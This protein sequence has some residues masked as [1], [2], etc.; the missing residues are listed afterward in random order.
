MLTYVCE[1]ALG[2]EVVSLE[3]VRFGEIEVL[4]ASYTSSL[5]PHILVA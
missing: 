3:R 1:Q 2:Y 5:S 4:K